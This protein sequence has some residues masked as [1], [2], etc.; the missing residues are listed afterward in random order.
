MKYSYIIKLILP[1]K[2]CLVW[3]LEK[4]KLYIRLAFVTHTAFLLGSAGLDNTQSL[5]GNSD[6]AELLVGTHFQRI[7][8]SLQ[9]NEW[10]KS[11]F[12]I[13]LLANS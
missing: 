4:F 2:K 1:L 12:S 11:L 7:H 6:S 3:P 13:M 10:I 8:P 5:C 9:K